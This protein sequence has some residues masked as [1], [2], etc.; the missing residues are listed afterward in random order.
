MSFEDAFRGV[1][2]AEVQPITQNIE[3]LTQMVEYLADKVQRLETARGTTGIKKELLSL[4]DVENIVGRKQCWIY[5]QMHANAFPAQISMGSRVFW[6]RED[7][8]RFVDITKKGE[9][10]TVKNGTTEG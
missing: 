5:K 6:K 10:Y 8:E 2:S 9:V 7:I 3:R 4:R 1:V